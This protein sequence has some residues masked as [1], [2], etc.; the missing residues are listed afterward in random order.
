MPVLEFLVFKGLAAAAK[1]I[2]SKGLGL[3]VGTMLFKSAMTAGLGSTISTVVVVGAVIGGV[4]WT[5]DRIKLVDKSIAALKDNDIKGAALLLGKLVVTTPGL[6]VDNLPDT[7][8]KVALKAGLHGGKAFEFAEF[9]RGM[10]GDVTAAV[11]KLR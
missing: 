9:L 4:V 2:T 1:V 5:T 6:S 7:I 10:E 11:R 3:K 8:T